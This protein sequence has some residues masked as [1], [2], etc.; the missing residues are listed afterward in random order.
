M[1]GGCKESQTDVRNSE[2]ARERDSKEVHDY[3][4]FVPW[5]CLYLYMGNEVRGERRGTSQRVKRQLDGA[6]QVVKDPK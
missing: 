2:R 6:G 3:G 1:K 4:V 5:A